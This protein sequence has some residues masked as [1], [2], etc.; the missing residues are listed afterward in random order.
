[1]PSVTG[2]DDIL[3]K[4]STKWFPLA[5]NPDLNLYGYVKEG[6]DNYFQSKIGRSCSNFE[7]ILYTAY[8]LSS[9]GPYV[10]SVPTIGNLPEVIF[11]GSERRQPTKNDLR[12]FGRMS[13]DAILDGFR[14]CCR[15]IEAN[16]VAA[17]DR[18]NNFIEEI[19]AEFDISVVSLNYDNIIYRSLQGI[20]TGFDASTGRFGQDRLFSR[21]KWPCMLH[22]HGSVHFDMRT[23]GSDLHEVFW[24]PDLGKPLTQ[25]SFGRGSSPSVEGISFPTSAI[26]AGYGKPIQILRRPFRTYYSE[27]DRLVNGC[28][29]ILIAGYGFGDD[30]LNLAFE[31]FRD[32]QRRPVV[33]IG[34]ADDNAMT[35]SGHGWIDINSCDK[36]IFSFFATDHGSMRWLRGQV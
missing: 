27:L 10:A 34:W 24:Q 11:F 12:T 31:R 25:N 13:I 9:S 30:H 32:T 33:V 26:I 6:L 20:E 29:A 19:Q 17:F 21:T 14:E 5:S 1:M 16:K 28:D 22:L 15:L 4:H 35:V 2:V 23:Q 7:D 36:R 3:N 8:V 18:L